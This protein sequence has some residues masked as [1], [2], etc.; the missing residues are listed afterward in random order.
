MLPFPQERGL[1][2]PWGCGREV[3]TF[4]KWIFTLT[5]PGRKEY[6]WKALEIA[7]HLFQK[8]LHILKKLFAL[9]GETSAARQASAQ[10]EVSLVKSAHDMGLG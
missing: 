1:R 9:C 3:I 8:G 10:E 5:V 7:S 4:R 6:Y 2:G